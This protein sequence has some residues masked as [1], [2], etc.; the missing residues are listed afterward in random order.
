MPALAVLKERRDNLLFVVK[1]L[2]FLPKIQAP[3]QVQLEA[4]EKQIAEAERISLSDLSTDS[5]LGRHQH[6]PE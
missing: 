5:L 2:A 4:V 6:M 1:Q 3:F